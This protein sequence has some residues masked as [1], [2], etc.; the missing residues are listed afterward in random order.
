[1]V[2]SKIEHG[3][4]DNIPTPNP[5]IPMSVFWLGFQYFVFGIADLFNFVGLMEFFYSEATA[6]MRSLAT[7][8]SWTSLALG[9]FLS[10]VQ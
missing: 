1:M 6:R 7:A 5:P 2:I 9:Y 8:F 3:M 4:V 10:S